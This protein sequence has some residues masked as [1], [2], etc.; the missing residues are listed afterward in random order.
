MQQ[1]EGTFTLT[2]KRADLY[3]ALALLVAFGSGFGVAWGLYRS[4]TTSL[5]AA[6][7]SAFSQGPLAASQQPTDVQIDLEGRPYLGPE[8]APVTIVEFIDYGCPFC[9]QHAR[10]T[11]PQLLGEYE[12]NIKYVIFNFPISRLHPYAQQAAEAAECVNDQGKFWEYHDILFQNQSAQGEESLRL[13]AEDTGLDMDVFNVCLDSGAKTQLVLDDVQDGQGYGVS[14]TPTFFING[15]ILVGALP[16]S[17]FQTL[18][19]AE[20][21]R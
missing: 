10:E 2:M 9:G 13:Y 17:S 21:N 20:L 4:E 18:I 7:T 6:N 12:G 8:D 3:L 19:D 5:Q 15:Q 11:I 1:R 16:F 14:A